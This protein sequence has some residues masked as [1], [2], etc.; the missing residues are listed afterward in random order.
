MNKINSEQPANADLRMEKAKMSRSE[1]P[2]TTAIATVWIFISSSQA[3]VQ[4]SAISLSTTAE[5]RELTASFFV[6]AVGRACR[7]P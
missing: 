6:L 1:A 7:R 2:S 3:S 5:C 4:L